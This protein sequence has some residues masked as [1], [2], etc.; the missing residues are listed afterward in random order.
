MDLTGD[1]DVLVVGAGPTGLMLAAELA[2]AG[3]RVTVAERHAEPRRESRALSLHPRSRELLDQRGIADRLPAG[4]VAPVWHFGTLG[5]RLDFSALD[6][7]HGGTL[8]VGQ[9][10]IEALLEAWARELGAEILRGYKL[11]ELGRDA[12]GVDARLSGGAGR[13]AVRARWAVGCD[14]GRSAVREAAGIAFPGSPETLTG[15]LGDFA[16]TEPPPSSL[17]FARERPAGVLIVPMEGGLTRFALVDPARMRVPSREPVTLEEFRASLTAVCGTDFGV[18]RPHWLSR[19]GNATRLAERY[20]SGRVLL[21]GDAAHIH[22]P[23]AGQGLNTGLQ[24]AVNL[25]WK[26]AATVRGWAPPGLLDT[27]D[28]ERRPVGRALA[29]NTEAQTLLI[30]L[31]LTERYRRPGTALRGL[32]NELLGIEDVNRL[33]AERVSAL[34][35]AY[36]A[37]GPG[38][39]P[40]AGRRMPDFGLT[41]AGPADRLFALLADGRFVL[42]GLDGEHPAAEPWR[43]RVT[44][45]AVTAHERR[46]D[47]DGVRELLIR[48]DGHVAWASRTADPRTRAKERTAAL[49]AWAG[50]P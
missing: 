47:L 5:T 11:V 24:D 22:F 13:R 14:G 41:A 23:A 42:L 28:A 12:D 30:E 2:L 35:V 17:L 19:F 48:P 18:D 26:L 49:T 6:T 3:V 15:M 21:A 7:R 39:D 36:P 40:L 1:T 4:P 16:V 20:R 29:E 33:L 44:G 9:A 45:C 10:R 31:P 50:L 32:M 8:V 37:P 38:A 43:D 27:Y 34:G 25:G 46:A